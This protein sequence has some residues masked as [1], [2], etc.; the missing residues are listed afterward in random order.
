MRDVTKDMTMVFANDGLYTRDLWNLECHRQS[1]PEMRSHNEAAKA[2][3]PYSDRQGGE[4]YAIRVTN[5]IVREILTSDKY[6]AETGKELPMAPTL[7]Q[8]LP[9]AVAAMIAAQE[10]EVAKNRGGRPRKVV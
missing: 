4:Y 6:A 10:K 9:P 1:S 2:Y 8:E 3:L 5:Q 7:Q